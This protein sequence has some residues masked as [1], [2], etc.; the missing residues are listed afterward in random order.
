MNISCFHFHTK[1]KFN[2]GGHL[3]IDSCIPD[4]P[5]CCIQITLGL[6]SEKGN[7]DIH[8]NGGVIS[9]SFALSCGIWKTLVL[10]PVFRV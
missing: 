1:I 3:S 8:T 6:E 2:C 9:I 7:L 10:G 5:C 4:L